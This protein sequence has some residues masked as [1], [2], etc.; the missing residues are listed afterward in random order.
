VDNFVDKAAGTTAKPADSR[1]LPGCP[2]NGQRKNYQQ[3][4]RLA[5]AMAFVA[6]TGK[7]EI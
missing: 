5:P 2:E 4:Q 1:V 6:R 7:A 3:N